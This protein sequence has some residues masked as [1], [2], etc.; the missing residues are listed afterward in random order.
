MTPADVESAWLPAL[1]AAASPLEIVPGTTVAVMPD[2]ESLV[3][4]DCDEL[5]H[6]A[7]PYYT[8]TVSIRVRTP[9]LTEDP[10]PGHTAAMNRLHDALKDVAA[11]KAA[12]DDST[13]TL[14]GYYVQSSSR[15]IIAEHHVSEIELTCGLEET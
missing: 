7:G 12:F 9:A 15:D 3:I 11:V 8:A 5:D 14:G 1:S 10:L 2:G 6:R 4:V 13:M